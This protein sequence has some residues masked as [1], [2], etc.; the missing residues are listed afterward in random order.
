MLRL[1]LAQLHALVELTVVNRDRRL[2]R[3]ARKNGDVT[4]QSHTQLRD[5]F[6]LVVPFSNLAPKVVSVYVW[7][8]HLT[9][10]SN[11]SPGFVW[12]LDLP[13][14]GA[15]TSSDRHFLTNH[16]MH[17]ESVE[18]H[19]ISSRFILNCTT[20][21]VPLPV[22]GRYIV[23]SLLDLHKCYTGQASHRVLQKSY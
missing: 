17:F 4:A 10:G 6:G 20:D 22:N 8:Q 23:L 5:R 7:L 3:A 12:P 18:C 15:H 2:A 11:K 16:K 21:R 13:R 1:E 14:I 9:E 19:Q